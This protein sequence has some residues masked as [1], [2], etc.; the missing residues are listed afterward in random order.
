MKP[1]TRILSDEEI[2][3]FLTDVK[4]FADA[5]SKEKAFI[6]KRLREYPDLALQVH[7]IS[8]VLILLI[9]EKAKSE[10]KPNVFILLFSD[11]FKWISYFF[12]RIVEFFED[13]FMAFLTCIFW[14]CFFGTLALILKA[15]VMFILWLFF[16]F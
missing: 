14:V 2:V 3:I 4:A 16:H 10:V 6:A 1:Q 12:S 8:L 9:E 13:P 15:I 5:S 7:D 11:I